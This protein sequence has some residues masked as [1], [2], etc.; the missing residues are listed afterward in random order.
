MLTLRKTIFSGE[1]RYILDY[2]GEKPIDPNEVGRELT[3]GQIKFHPNGELIRVPLCSYGLYDN[4]TV[5]ERSNYEV[6]VR[7]YGEMP[8]LIRVFGLSGRGIYIHEQV[9]ERFNSEDAPEL[10]PLECEFFDAIQNLERYPV[11]DEDHYMALEASLEAEAWNDWLFD[12][13]LGALCRAMRKVGWGDS[14]V[15]IIEAG[16]REN[17]DEFRCWFYSQILESGTQFI[18]DNSGGPYLDV[19]AVVAYIFEV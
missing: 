14:K 16:L 2:Y 5:L 13:A 7:D 18:H 6:I 15:D 4:T 11:L 10:Y 17:A 9:L 19:E 3:Y 12:E 1:P 8:G